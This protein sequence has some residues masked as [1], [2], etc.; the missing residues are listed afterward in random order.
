MESWITR[1]FQLDLRRGSLDRVQIFRRQFNL[2]RP[3]VLIQA[4]ELRC[5]RNGNNPWLLRQQP[6]ER[7]LRWCCVLLLSKR[8]NQIYEGL[9]RPPI[10]LLKAR[11][12]ATK[13]AVVELGVCC[14]L[15]GQ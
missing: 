11:N 14:D 9:I 7:N 3:E 12:V 13:I 6:R 1:P 2:Q 5:A 8:C 4:V 15:A 10:L